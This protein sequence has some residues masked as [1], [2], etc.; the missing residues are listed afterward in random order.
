MSVKVKVKHHIKPKKTAKEITFDAYEKNLKLNLEAKRKD[1]DNIMTSVIP[2]QLVLVKTYLWVSSLSFPTL[3]LI[4]TKKEHAPDGWALFFL[5]LGALVGII[6]M[7]LSLLAIHSTKERYVAHVEAEEDFIQ[8][9]QDE[10]EHTQGLLTMLKITTNSIQLGT[11]IVNK[12]GKFLRAI[13]LLMFPYIFFMVSGVILCIPNNINTMKEDSALIP[14]LS[15]NTNTMKGGIN[16]AED[17]K[18]A[19]P[20]APTQPVKQPAVLQA[21]S[22]EIFED[23]IRKDYRGG[24][25]STADHK[26]K[27]SDK[28]QTKPKK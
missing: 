13:F 21:N 10:L 6:N 22:R 7:L 9:A 18:N 24:V 27:I 26:D 1:F 8:I 17:P 16:M 11:K 25:V 28:N 4:F 20:T 23:V 14:S 15:S 5:C 3:I 19:R 2:S 12:T